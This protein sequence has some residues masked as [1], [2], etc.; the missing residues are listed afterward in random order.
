MSHIE[1][2]LDGA[3]ELGINLTE[4]KL[5]LFS[6]YL[7]DLKKWNRVY[8]LTAIRDDKDI[9]IKHFIDSLSYLKA[10]PVRKGLKVIDI[11]T[12]A[13]FP[14]IP[15]KIC[16]PEIILT[17]VDSSMKKTL[18]LKHICRVLGL[19]NVEI[20]QKRAEEHMEVFGSSFDVLVTRALYKIKDLLKFGIPVLKS[21]GFLV[22]SKG[23]VTEK[24][25][26]ETSKIISEIDVRFK[27]VINITLPHSN[28][29][30]NL[31]VFERY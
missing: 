30:R 20:I 15:I 21:G 11:G 26:K 14:G 27:D 12:G 25:L 6:I 1:L 13:G 29:K 23:P 7:K 31:I 3:R 22:I 28:I 5:K 10:I 4:E 9:V 19:A 17:L 8:N 24:E 18:F 16:H 2:L